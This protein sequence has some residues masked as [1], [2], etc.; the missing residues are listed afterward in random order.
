MIRVLFV[1]SGQGE[2]RITRTGNADE[3]QVAKLRGGRG[4]KALGTSLP[5]IGSGTARAD[6]AGPD[7]VVLDAPA[8]AGIPGA[9]EAGYYLVLDLHPSQVDLSE[10]G[11]IE[12]C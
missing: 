11:H 12:M 3:G 7:H 10:K 9:T 4:L 6:F 1:K 8:R 5:V 2:N